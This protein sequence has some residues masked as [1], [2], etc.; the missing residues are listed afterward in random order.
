M[1]NVDLV[2]EDEALVAIVKSA[3]V[4]KT[5]ARGPRSI[6][7]AAMLDIMFSLPR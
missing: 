5:G 3:K 2:F 4:R 6:M 7:E 1:E